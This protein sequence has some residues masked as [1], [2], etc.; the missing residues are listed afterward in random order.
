MSWLSQLSM[1][2]YLLSTLIQYSYSMPDITKHFLELLPEELAY[3]HINGYING[4]WPRWFSVLGIRVPKW[5]LQFAS[6]DWHD[7]GYLQGY[8][9]EHWWRIDQILCGMWRKCECDVKFYRAMIIDIIHLPIGAN[10]IYWFLSATIYFLLVL[11][12][13][14]MSFNWRWVKS[15]F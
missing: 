13:G 11:S 12:C 15:Y 7:Y 6:C 2:V 14:W 10:W 5:A 3:F 1:S 8:K 9:V 4:C